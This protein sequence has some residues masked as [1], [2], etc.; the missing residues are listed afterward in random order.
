MVKPYLLIAIAIATFLAG[1]GI[2]CAIFINTYNPY[3]MMMQ[4]PQYMN[5]WMNQNPQ[6]TSQWM[7][8]MMSDP[9]LRSHMYDSMLQN[10]QFMYGMMGNT[11]FQNNYMH[12]WMN[13]NNYTWHGMMG[14]YP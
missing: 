1:I 7:G 10:Q 3:E 14:N 13:K 6:Y 4:H 2:G 5:Q 9:H 11:N 12:N 8:Q